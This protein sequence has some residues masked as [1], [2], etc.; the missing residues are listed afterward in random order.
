MKK[1]IVFS[2]VL[3]AIS[4]LAA[5]AFQ[6]VVG[7]P[8]PLGYTLF[9]VVYM[10][11]PLIVALVM[12][13]CERSTKE[14]LGML[15]F[16][17]RW[18]W[19]VGALL[20]PVTLGLCA[21]VGMLFAEP[22]SMA[23]SLRMQITAALGD[24]PE[25]EKALAEINKVPGWVM[26]VGTI[27]SGLLAGATINAVAAFGEE[28]GWRYYLV[29]KLRD[30]KFLPA[31][32]FI[33]IVWGIWHAPM[34]LLFGHNYPNDRVAGI[35]MM[36]ILCILLGIIELYFVVKSGSMWPSAII[37]GTFNGISGMA[38]LWF[39]TGSALTTGMTGVAGFVAM[40][41]VIA[42]LWLYDRKHDNIFASTIEAKLNNEND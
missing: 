22:V 17:P 32:L 37:H 12:Q 40:G 1:A 24:T 6:A 36:V 8:A 35:G 30:K 9:G 21:L 25:A 19:L 10:F 41:I 33:G 15:H 31:S 2:V 20:V 11:L 18:S 38:L 14:S 29:S 42:A 39:P 5:L 27:V 3:C 34:I 28:Y 16:R 13:L 4:W 26:G 7:T 23:E